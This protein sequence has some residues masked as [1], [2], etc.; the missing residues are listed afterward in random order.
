[1]LPTE[2]SPF[3]S[4]FRNTK[5]LVTSSKSY[6]SLSR[7]SERAIQFWKVFVLTQAGNPVVSVRID[8]QEH[9]VPN[10]LVRQLRTASVE[11]LEQLVLA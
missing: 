11:P 9:S 7:R 10:F 6:R 8:H 1:M 2:P 5:N 4:R 3:S